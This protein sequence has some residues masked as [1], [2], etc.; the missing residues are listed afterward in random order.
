MDTWMNINHMESTITKLLVSIQFIDHIANSNLNKLEWNIFVEEYR[1]SK[2]Q[3][4]W[5][6]A[7]C[8]PLL[9]FSSMKEKY[10]T[11]ISPFLLELPQYV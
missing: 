1:W 5:A 10:S 4:W 9:N 11:L 7:M 6:Q 2:V 3:W 8:S